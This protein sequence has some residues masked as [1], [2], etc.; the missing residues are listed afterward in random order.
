M[1]NEGTNTANYHFHLLRKFLEYWDDHHCRHESY[2][3]YSYG[4]RKCIDCGDVFH[5]DRILIAEPYFVLDARRLLE[6]PAPPANTEPS[7][8]DLYP[9]LP[10]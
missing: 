5:K 7:W 8:L 3:D 4:W 9:S 1:M 6:D 10:L 2:E